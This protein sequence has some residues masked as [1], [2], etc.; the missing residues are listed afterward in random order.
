VHGVGPHLDVRHLGIG[1]EGTPRARY[2]PT[3]GEVERDARAVADGGVGHSRA[4]WVVASGLTG[5]QLEGVSYA[6]ILEILEQ[7]A[8]VRVYG[9]L[10]G[11]MTR[12]AHHRGQITKPLDYCV[13][14]VWKW[15]RVVCS[16]QRGRKRRAGDEVEQCEEWR[17]RKA[18]VKRIAQ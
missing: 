2:G 12:S 1:H 16:W 18:L 6:G 10:E 17:R 8:V 9:A 7:D 3:V 14:R 15:T 13:K 4:I 5:D 11:E